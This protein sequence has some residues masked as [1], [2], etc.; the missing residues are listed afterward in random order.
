M[1]QVKL[2]EMVERRKSVVEGPHSVPL[3][4]PEVGPLELAQP[5]GAFQEPGRGGV[6]GAA[7][8][9]EKRGGRITYCVCII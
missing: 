5:A 2:K 4:I 1:L 9:D 3:L 7:G 8:K 6:A